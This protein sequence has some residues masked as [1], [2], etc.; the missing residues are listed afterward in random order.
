M[1]SINFL[2]IN[3]FLDKLI[4]EKSKWRLPREC[5]LLLNIQAACIFEQPIDSGHYRFSYFISSFIFKSQKQLFF[6]LPGVNIDLQP[7]TKSMQISCKIKGNSLLPR[8]AFR[9]QFEVNAVGRL[10]VKNQQ[11]TLSLN[12]LNVNSTLVLERPVK[13]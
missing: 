8:V 9:D 3:S 12:N 1:N 11:K 7:S 6:F 13:G 4:F 2:W 5:I 10:I